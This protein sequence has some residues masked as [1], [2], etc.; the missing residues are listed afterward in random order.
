M[1]K[2]S[3]FPLILTALFLIALFLTPNPSVKGQTIQGSIVINADGTITPNN[4]S[5]PIKREGNTYFLTGDIYGSITVECSNIAI[6]GNGFSLNLDMSTLATERENWTGSIG[7]RLNHVNN[8]TITNTIISDFHDVYFNGIAYEGWG[9]RLEASS[10][11]KIYENT[12]VGNGDGVKSSRSSNNDI[13]CNSI[14]NNSEVGI[15]LYS[16]SNNNHIFNNSIDSNRYGIVLSSSQDNTINYNNI[17]NHKNRTDVGVREGVG[18]WASFDAK[19]NHF[20]LNNLINNSRNALVSGTNANSWDDGGFGN[21]WSDYQTKYPHAS[22]DKNGVADTPYGVTIDGM[23]R[24]HAIPNY[25]I[26]HYPLAEPVSL[27][28]PQAPVYVP[29]FSALIILPLLLVA[30]VAAIAL[31]HQRT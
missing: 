23:D 26:D 22:S 8:V 17:G 2:I 11:V 21:Y 10:N 25:N 3:I 29:E 19:H 27:D 9:I 15:S 6:F 16:S 28:T 30:L 7:L 13:Y 12:I 14:I 20:Y 24:T 4:A 1:K 31:R 5:V 18:I